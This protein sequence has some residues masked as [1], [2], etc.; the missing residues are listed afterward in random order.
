[1]ALHL[2]SKL[3]S[4]TQYSFRREDNE[5]TVSFGIDER[6]SF[7]VLA[8]VK[9]ALKQMNHITACEAKQK[10][11]RLQNGVRL[12]KSSVTRHQAYEQSLPAVK[13]R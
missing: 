1:M 10:H 13:K 8:C 6:L 9:N 11:S 4:N 2:P 7:P 3:S 12:Q 5:K